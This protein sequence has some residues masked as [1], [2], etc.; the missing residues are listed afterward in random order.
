VTRAEIAGAAESGWVDLQKK[1]TFADAAKVFVLA[2]AS[3][4]RD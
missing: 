4:R 1:F 2:L 3:K